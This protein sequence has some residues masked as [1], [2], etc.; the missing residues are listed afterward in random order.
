MAKRKIETWFM[1]SRTKGSKNGE[2]MYQF[3][4]GTYTELGKERRRKGKLSK[5]HDVTVDKAKKIGQRFATMRKD[6][7]NFTLETLENVTSPSAQVWA[8]AVAFTSIAYLSL[9]I[10]QHLVLPSV[11][12]AAVVNTIE[13]GI[14]KSKKQRAK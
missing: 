8:G 2:R 6:L 14:S 10:S 3:E 4:D 1:H 9:G 12:I 11:A 13:E 5:L 7:A